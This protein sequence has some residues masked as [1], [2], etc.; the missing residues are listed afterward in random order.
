MDTNSPP[1]STGGHRKVA[2]IASSTILDVSDLNELDD[3]VQ[4]AIDE[5][6][7]WSQRAVALSAL[8]DKLQTLRGGDDAVR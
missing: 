2:Q 7:R 4:S 1:T 8:A 6:L 5:A 3:L